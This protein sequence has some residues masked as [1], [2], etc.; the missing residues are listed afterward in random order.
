MRGGWEGGKVYHSLF[1]KSEK[2]VPHFPERNYAIIYI[3][4]LIFAHR[5]FLFVEKGDKKSS[6]TG[7]AF[8][9]GGPLLPI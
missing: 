6:S 5:S 2:I 4:S 8:F 3:K 1:M 7:R 9:F